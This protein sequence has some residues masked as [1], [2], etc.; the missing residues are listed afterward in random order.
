MKTGT[1]TRAKPTNKPVRVRGA[2]VDLTNGVP[3]SPVEDLMM[4]A[5]AA[6]F[7]RAPEDEIRKMAETAKLPAR[8]VAGEWRF[9]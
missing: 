5:E 1:S 4:L 9:F 7:L 8:R 2:S 6:T 3:A